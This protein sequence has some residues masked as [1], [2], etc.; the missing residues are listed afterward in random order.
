MT[1]FGK[2]RFHCSFMSLRISAGSVLS[3]RRMYY[4]KQIQSNCISLAKLERG[5]GM[6]RV[7]LG[8]KERNPLSFLV[9]KL[10]SELESHKS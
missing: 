9:T 4:D 10:T 1:K 6:R 2:P 3:A 7:V 8:L 5:G